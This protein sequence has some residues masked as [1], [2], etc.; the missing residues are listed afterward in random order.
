MELPNSFSE[1]EK[2]V[3]ELLLQGK[4]N[5]Q[6]A[7]SLGITNRTVEYHMGN[8][9]AKL[10][11]SS[12]SEAILAITNY[13]NHPS[14]YSEVEDLWES[15]VVNA[16]EVVNNGQKPPRRIL[17]KKSK[18][19]FAGLGLLAGILIIY[20]AFPKIWGRSAY[21]PETARLPDATVSSSPSAL[22]SQ[23]QTIPVDDQYSF[24]QTIDSVNVR[25][26]INWFYIDESR[27]NLEL[28]ICG[29]PMP[30]GFKPVYLIDPAKL[31]LTYADG[32]PIL[33]VQRDNSGSEGGGGEDQVSDEK[34]SC[35]RQTFD[36]SFSNDQR[37][38]SQD[39]TYTLDITIGGSITG[40]TG[41]VKSL[42]STTFHVQVKPTYS[43]LLT[44]ATNKSAEIDNKTVTFKG[45][46]VN[47]SS[48]AVILCVNAPIGEQWIPEV[49]ILYKGNIIYG[50]SGGLMDS[51]N[52]D[53]ATEMCYRLN[54]SYPFQIDTNF[55]PKADLSILVAKLTTVQPERLSYEV[56]AH[57]QNKLGDEGIE[58]SYVVI[59]HGSYISIT[60]KPEGMTEAEAVQKAL[61]FLTEKAI[62][63]KVIL[64]D[65]N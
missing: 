41:E 44:F 45:I 4:S 48:A 36:Y 2:A 38:I 5:K 40:D 62:P 6:I 58:F 34:E 46:E 55:A 49:E 43:G 59:S 42:L 8:I 21:M 7:L 1:R 11:V 17:M 47:P 52:E 27:V 65:L 35:Y 57:A 31:A 18:Y 3:V 64:F 50:F 10:G 9:F 61:D 24:T 54:Y 22:P 51:T 16:P 19:F 37:E 30:D 29:L 32:K 33:L 53:P 13:K 20:F 63:S 12:R 28:A 14:N 23:E 15:T 25:L 39:D 26:L 60:K 56:V